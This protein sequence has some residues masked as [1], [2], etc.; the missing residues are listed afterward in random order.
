MHWTVVP[1]ASVAPVSF[2]PT[3]WPMLK[4]AIDPDHWSMFEPTGEPAP[5]HPTTIVDPENAGLPP[6]A[7]ESMGQ[8]A[9]PPLPIP[10]Q[11]QRL[12]AQ[13]IALKEHNQRLVVQQERYMSRISQLTSQLDI[14]LSRSDRAG[15]Q[16]QNLTRQLDRQR[17]RANRVLD[18][19][20]VY[21]ATPAPNP[22]V[23]NAQ[24]HYVQLPF[25]QRKQHRAIVR[26]CLHLIAASGV[27][28]FAYL[29][30]LCV[31]Q[32]LGQGAL[33]G[34]FGDVTVWLL[35]AIG[36]ID[37]VSLAVAWAAEAW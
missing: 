32:I 25:W 23:R 29:L 20:P 9:P 19:T 34:A 33:V 21:D 13:I 7:P 15:S 22:A 36:V 5:A 14:A 2:P 12:M 11:T 30:G 17:H 1:S 27:V 26:F 35:R 28:L 31:L 24:G 4:P 8:V 37:L 18:V 6:P 3:P 10:L 16:V